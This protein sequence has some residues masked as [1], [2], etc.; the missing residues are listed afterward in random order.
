MDNQTL[1]DQ[2][3]LNSEI[4]A[5]DFATAEYP[6]GVLNSE[7]AKTLYPN[8]GN[9][10]IKSAN[11]VSGSTG[12]AI[13]NSGTAEFRNAV[14]RGTILADTGVL[15][16]VIINDTCTIKGTL[17]ANKIVGDVYNRS[18]LPWLVNN[19][20]DGGNFLGIDYDYVEVFAATV[21]KL[22]TGID[23]VRIV[24]FGSFVYTTSE[25]TSE[26]DIGYFIGGV[27]IAHEVNGFVFEHSTPW[28]GDKE[29]SRYVS[30]ATAT[31]G[32]SAD[33]EISVK[34]RRR[35]RNGKHTGNGE[36]G[37]PYGKGT[38]SLAVYRK[39]SSIGV[40]RLSTT[41]GGVTTTITEPFFPDPTRPTVP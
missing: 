14:I 11:Y 30:G 24:D 22:P 10:N 35:K 41:S 12:W 28:T 9:I 3:I 6:E 34:M 23:Y 36:I 33:A 21:Y 18:S 29:S 39:E 26:F 17:T 20:T 7:L 27:Q 5:V 4:P 32:P 38:M 19:G 1:L 40:H 2:G 31:I 15:N 16:N 13:D 25:E 8:Q 37:V